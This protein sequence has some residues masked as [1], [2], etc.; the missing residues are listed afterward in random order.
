LDLSPE[1]ILP[2]GGYITAAGSHAFDYY[3]GMPI[4]EGCAHKPWL[5]RS[6]T[7]NGGRW[8][9]QAQIKRN[10]E[11]GVE[12]MTLH[13]DGDVNH[14]GLYWHDGSWPPYP[15]EQMKRMAETIED[16]PKNGI[17]TVPYFSDHELHQSTE[18]FKRHGEEWGSKSDDQGDLRP[19]FDYGALMCLKSGWLDYLKFCVDRVLKSCPFDGVYYDWNQAL[20]CNNPV[21]VGKTSNGVSGVKGLGTY[22]LSPT[23][24]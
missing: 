9:P 15:P 18:A 13:D 7:P 16:C 10:A 5:E 8:V 12:T 22:A 21:H 11:L 17:K 20:Y 2:R 4:L 6:Y 14:D 19:N 1:Y 24:H 3:I 23:G